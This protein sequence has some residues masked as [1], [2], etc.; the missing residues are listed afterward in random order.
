MHVYYYGIIITITSS[1]SFTLIYDNRRKDCYI[2]VS[3]TSYMPPTNI[4]NWCCGMGGV[5]RFAS[6]MQIYT[7]GLSQYYYYYYY[8]LPLTEHK[9]KDIAD[10]SEYTTLHTT[11]LL[12]LRVGQQFCSSQSLDRFLHW[13]KLLWQKDIADVFPSASDL[14][15]VLDRAVGDLADRTNGSSRWRHWQSYTVNDNILIQPNRSTT[16]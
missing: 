14:R 2:L 5:C 10:H 11:N 16:Q 7:Y 9:A 8:Y 1:S 13:K 15:C 6:Y 4:V 12:S 3:M